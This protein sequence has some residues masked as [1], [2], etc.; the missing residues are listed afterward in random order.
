MQVKALIN[1]MRLCTLPLSLAGVVCGGLSVQGEHSYNWW[2]FA[3]G[4]VFTK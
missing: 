3:S 4:K 2:A 1:S